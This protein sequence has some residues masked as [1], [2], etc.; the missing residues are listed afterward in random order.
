MNSIS[1]LPEINFFLKQKE[2]NNE[3]SIN[4]LKVKAKVN[5]KKC[6]FCEQVC[7]DFVSIC[8]NCE[9]ERKKKR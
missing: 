2:N 7:Y 3:F 6:W 1:F 5:N 9:T 4:I 8:K